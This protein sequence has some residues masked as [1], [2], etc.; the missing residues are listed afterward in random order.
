MYYYLAVV[1]FIL[2]LF[3]GF[4]N[5][6]IVIQKTVFFI[7]A[8]LF[9]IIQGFNTWSPDM[10]SYRIHFDD[11]DEDYVINSVEPLH[12]KIIEF[13][14]WAGGDFKDFI[15]FYGLLIMSL[16]LFSIKKYS[17]LPVFLLLNFYFIPF[18]PDIVQIR[19]FLGFS[20]FLVALQYFNK[21]NIR[22]YVLYFISLLCHF[23]L[24]IF[25]PF[26]FLR[27]MTFFSNQKNNNIIII[28]GSLLLLLV[29]KSFS[30]PLIVF[31]NPKY[32]T[33]LE[34]T[35]TYLGTIILFLPF[36]II[37]NIALYHFNTF[38]KNIKT[39]IDLKYRKN[40]P[41]FMQLIQY[42]NYMILPQY[43]IRDFSRITMNLHILTLIY[44]SYILY[45]GWSKKYNERKVVF[46]K[47]LF[48][49]GSVLM[50]YFNFLLLNNGEY[51]EIIEKNFASNSI[52][53]K[54]F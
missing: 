39:E 33:F 21:N 36:F 44:F 35:S 20:V 48:L 17:P 24:L 10:E 15:F 9:I 14:R 26:F 46:Y 4:F 18:F 28:T 27:K 50:F 43:F 2:M 37:N 3:E 7:T 5:K 34:A 51:M 42:S 16:F 47:S 41:F 40:I 1:L 38:Y 12:I 49:V 11:Y 29:P 53:E 54:I 13:V 22:F 30:E 45:I 23:A 32:S 52:L 19:V 6:V 8:I 25:L 31:I